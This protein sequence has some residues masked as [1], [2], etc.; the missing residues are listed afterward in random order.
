VPVG[1][2]GRLAQACSA[3]LL[4]DYVSTYLALLYGVD[5][6]PVDAIAQVKRRLSARESDDEED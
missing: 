6:L 4:G 3:I 1:G 2:E 5:P